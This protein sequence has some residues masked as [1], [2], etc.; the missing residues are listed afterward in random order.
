[1]NRKVIRTADGSKTIEL[2]ELGETYHSRHGALVEA[3]HVFIESGLL[4]WLNV[5]STA[6]SIDIFEMG[7]GTG[8]NAILTF[9]EPQL[10]NR[11]C[12][13]HAIEAFPVSLEELAELDTA[14]W[15]SKE[16]ILGV[17]NAPWDKIYQ[18]KPGCTLLKQVIKW[19]DFESQ[20]QFDLIYFDAFGARTQPEL[21][22]DDQFIKCAQLLKPG[23]VFVT[24]SSKGSVRRALQSANLQVEKI[25]G[26]PGKREMLRAIKSNADV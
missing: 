24:Y 22:S 25:P 1:M 16:A 2:T 6:R 9:D 11:S 4:Y 15:G 20:T 5:H 14:S 26:P 12:N 18:V 17:Q 7:L 13:Y 10:T 23:G 21:W 19:E 8:M 3:R